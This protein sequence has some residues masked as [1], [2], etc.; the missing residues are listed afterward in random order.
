[1]KS[2]TLCLALIATTVFSTV[3]NDALFNSRRRML[4]TCMKTQCNGAISNDWRTWTQAF[5][6]LALPNANRG[7]ANNIAYG[8]VPNPA[9]ACSGKA[10]LYAEINQARTNP[11]RLAKFIQQNLCNGQL[12]VDK[13]TASETINFLLWMAQN[14]KNDVK[15]LP[16]MTC[17]NKA[18][19]QVGTDNVGQYR[20]VNCQQ[21]SHMAAG[22]SP[23]QR[24]GMF[25]KKDNTACEWNSGECILGWPKPISCL[26]MVAIWY[27]DHGVVNKGHRRVMIGAGASGI[28]ASV[29]TCGA[30]IFASASLPVGYNC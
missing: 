24:I 7:C 1:M 25:A 14:C 11:T 21:I 28:G 19:S 30:G 6:V 8:A 20:N 26:S 27:L 9:G 12:A 17:A 29:K 16:Q 5:P 3:S 18:A 13:N 22:H 2:L 10:A 23:D 15:S 4:G